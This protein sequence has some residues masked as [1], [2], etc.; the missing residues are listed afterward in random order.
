MDR[1]IKTVP[2]METFLRGRDL[3]SFYRADDPMHRDLQLFMSETL[4]SPRADGLIFNTFED[5]EG[6]ILSQIRTYC[7]KVYTIGPLNAHLRARIPQN[8]TFSN[9]F[10]EVDRSCMEWLDKQPSRSV[11][12]VS[13]GSIA[14]VSREQLLEFWFGLA[15]SKQRFLWVIRPDSITGNVGEN[16]IPEE[17]VEATKERG[18]MVGWVPQEEILAHEALGAFL[19]HSGWNS[20][21]ESII[22]GIPMICWPYFGDQQM[23]SRFVDEVW[24]LGL[25]MKDLCDTKIVEK[26]VNDLIVDRRE[27]FMKSADRMA[28]LA[29]KSVNKG[30]SSYNNLDRL[31]NDIK[32]MSSQQAES[33][34]QD[35][36]GC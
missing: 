3:P 32:I 31:I 15:R 36:N 20:T 1:L 7:P 18:Y 4:S 30:G 23:N 13:F 6:P 11:I 8:T 27:E 5:L 28:N 16:Q 35:V 25:D 2:G 14:V 17:L 22:A 19:T 34:V 26:M 10:W 29:R 12:Y 33:L 9:S 24:K 21:L